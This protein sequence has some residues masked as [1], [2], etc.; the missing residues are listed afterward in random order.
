M[1][2]PHLASVTTFALAFSL[3]GSSLA[4]QNI[5]YLSPMFTRS[6][7]SDIVYGGNTNPWTNQYD[8]LKLDVHEPVGDTA[9]A[10]PGYLHV[11]GGQF[12]YGSK[13][14]A[15]CTWLADHFTSRGWVTIACDYRLAPTYNHGNMAP[16]VSAQHTNAEVR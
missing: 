15:E 5:R 9:P 4:A 10:R 8:T 1:Q 13:T 16:D 11:H 14:N 3:L 7:M 6:V 2:S 12:F